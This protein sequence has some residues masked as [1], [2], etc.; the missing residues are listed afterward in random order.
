MLEE[1]GVHEEEA[2][3]T[4]GGALTAMERTALLNMEARGRRVASRE[5]VAVRTRLYLRSCLASRARAR[6]FRGNQPGPASA[7]VPLDPDKDDVALAS[8]VRAADHAHELSCITI[9]SRDGS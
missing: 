4:A 3:S 6:V 8:S 1:W 7:S 9:K 2:P 5:N